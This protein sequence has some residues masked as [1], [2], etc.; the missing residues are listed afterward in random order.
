MRKLLIFVFLVTAVSFIGNLSASAQKVEPTPQPRAKDLYTQYN[1]D[2]QK[3][4]G[5]PGI[6]ISIL[7]KRGNRAERFVAPNET[8]YSGDKIKLVLDI[9]FNGYA[10]ILNEGTTG[11]M[12]LLFPFMDGSELVSHRV[13]PNTGTK[14]PRGNA[15][16]TFDRN[17]G[18]EKVTVV[19]SK[20]SIVEL[21]S[22]KSLSLGGA[23]S[24]DE[25]D[26]ILVELNSQGIR[27]SKDL[28]VQNEMDA[29][30]FVCQ[31]NDFN[32]QLAFTFA[33]IHK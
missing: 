24:A 15:W 19:F 3:T 20:D 8:F 1:E 29:S 13:S 5:R 14:L 7:L 27:R 32:G 17:P 6:K 16:I 31:R 21:Q 4:K 9:N 22:Y 28:F 30:Y 23:V 2:N 11:K 10:A 26:Q 12:N 25:A 33:L 18:N